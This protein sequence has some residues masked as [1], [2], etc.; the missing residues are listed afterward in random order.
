MGDYSTKKG[1]YTPKV[2]LPIKM[3]ALPLEK[4]LPH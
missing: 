2:D 3:G 1:G 4:D